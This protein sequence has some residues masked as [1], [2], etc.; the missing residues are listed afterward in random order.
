MSRA[1]LFVIGQFVLFGIMAITLIV[2]PLGGSTPLRIVG[3]ALIAVG[4]AVLMIA[5]WEHLR[6]N[7]TL[8]YV[9]PTPNMHVGLVETGLYAHVRHPIYSGVLT[10]AVGVALAHGHLVP[11]IVALVMIIFFTFKSRH[12]ERLL[13]AIYPEY[14]AYMTHTGRF[15]PFL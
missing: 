9:T 12:E 2:Y 8:P 15:L 6:R 11:M 13:R 5:I 7:A 14:A 4:F 3:L 1:T 10:G